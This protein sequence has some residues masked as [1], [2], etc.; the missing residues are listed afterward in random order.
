MRPAGLGNIIVSTVEI[1]LNA[2]FFNYQTDC[3]SISPNWRRANSTP[4]P[5]FQVLDGMMTMKMEAMKVDN[6]ICW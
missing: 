2:C 5:D 3:F 4:Y 1:D 6:Y